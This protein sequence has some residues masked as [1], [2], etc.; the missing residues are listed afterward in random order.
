MEWLVAPDRRDVGGTQYVSWG[1]RVICYGIM[2]RTADDPARLPQSA[3]WA[4][5]DRTLAWPP[6]G[7]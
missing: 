1:G 6:A 2:I 3:W 4:D 7:A 5:V